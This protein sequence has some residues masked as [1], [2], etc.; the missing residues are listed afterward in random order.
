MFC[1]LAISFMHFHSGLFSTKCVWIIIAFDR[2]VFGYNEKVLIFELKCLN[3]KFFFFSKFFQHRR[4]SNKRKEKQC[5]DDFK[6]KN[7]ELFL[8]HIINNSINI[9]TEIYIF[10]N[11]YTKK[12][13]NWRVLCYETNIQRIRIVRRRQNISKTQKRRIITQSKIY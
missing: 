3:E 5:S 6:N 7:L 2:F 12:K 8:V 9:I 13:K 11:I 1:F 4:I 10:I